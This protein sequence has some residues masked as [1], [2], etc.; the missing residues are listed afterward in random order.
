MPQHPA[1]RSGKRRSSFSTTSEDVRGRF[2]RRRAISFREIT[3]GTCVAGLRPV[4][5]AD[6]FGAAKNVA[7]PLK[8]SLYPVPGRRRARRPVDRA[9]SKTSPSVGRRREIIR[10]AGRLAAPSSAAPRNP[11]ANSPS[12]DC[13]RHGRGGSPNP[14]QS[15]P[16]IVSIGS[17]QWQDYWET[18][19][20]DVASGLERRPRRR[21]ERKWIGIESEAD[22]NHLPRVE[23]NRSREYVM[24]AGDLPGKARTRQRLR[25]ETRSGTRG[26]AKCVCWATVSS[27]EM[28]PD[29]SVSPPR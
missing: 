28:Q 26:R 5:R 6:S 15:L 9:G 21:C 8:R 13:Q 17:G 11:N 27:I 4:R 7:V 16:W 1:G 14:P 2:L 24:D 25:R 22:L 3:G 19:S 12:G 29:G 20:D 23:R 10:S 18:P